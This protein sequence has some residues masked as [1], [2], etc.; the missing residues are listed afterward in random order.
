MYRINGYYLL[1]PTGNI[2]ILAE[3]PDCAE[4]LSELPSIAASLMDLEPSAEQVGFLSAGDEAADICLTMAGGEFCGNA[5]LSAAAVYAY[6]NRDAG[7]N[8]E[9]VSVKVK[10]SGTNAPVNVLLKKQEDRVY[11][12]AVAMPS[13]QRISVRRFDWNGKKYSFPTVDFQGITH[14]ICE[15][16]SVELFSDRKALELAVKYWCGELDA[17]ALGIMLTDYERRSLVP[18]VYV[19]S[20]GTLF[21]ESS[22]ASGTCA[23]G[24]YYADRHGGRA[25]L[26][27]EEPAGKLAVEVFPDG[28][29]TLLGNV[30]LQKISPD[31][32]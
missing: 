26:S 30:I 10:V 19:A 1:N 8:G 2:T 25:S 29:I 31:P 22:C 24:V 16:E 23:A 9:G 14:I 3:K 4:H 13:A 28:K 12:G 15:P 6:K 20:A 27:F 5:T 11:S 17:D 18:L 21:W 32:I 7:E